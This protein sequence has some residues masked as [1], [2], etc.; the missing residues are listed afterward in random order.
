MRVAV[1]GHV[2]WILFGRVARVPRPGEIVHAD[3]WWEDVGG[4]GSVAAVQLVKLAGTC[5]FFTAL[6][7]DEL[8]RRALEALV[9]RGVEVRPA[10]RPEPQRRGFTHLDAAGERTIT[11]MGERLAPRGVDPLGWE[12]LRD[13]DA[14]YVTAGDRDALRATRRAGVVVATSRIASDLAEA[15]LPLDALVGS[16]RDPAER[17]APGSIDPPPRLEV[18]TAGAAGG[19]Y[20]TALGAEGSFPAAPP[21]GPVADSYGCGDSF[22]AGLTFGLGTGLPPEEALALGARC[23]AACL[24]GHG[25]YEGQLRVAPAGP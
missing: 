4:A 22:A 10:F 2:E 1:V 23:G 16:L 7:E 15:G 11:V 17:Y 25:P 14:V 18:F 3:E 24:T 19:T 9:A 13:H 20:R 21:P 12:D 8:G 6:G 5:T